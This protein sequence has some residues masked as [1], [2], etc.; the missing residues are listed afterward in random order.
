MQAWVNGHIVTDPDAPAV[1]VT[2]RGFT[3]GAGVFETLKVLDG[4]PFALT[5]HL[6]RLNHGAAVLGIDSPDDALVRRGVA[7]VLAAEAHPLQRLR[8]TW[9]GTTLAITSTAFASYSPTTA[10]V[11]S[12]WPRNE[13]SPLVG[14]KSTAFAENILSTAHAAKHD[15]GEAIL[16]NLNGDLC[17][18]AG[19]N[20]FYVLDGELRTPT[21]E[22]GCLPG[23]TRDLVLEWFGAREVDAPLG[24]L[25][26][27]D[28]VFL[29]SS[30]R[31]VQ[32]VHAID[33]RALGAPGPVTTEVA[34]VWAER[35]AQSLDP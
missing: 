23:V 2:D 12:P 17:E 35:E 16:A 28:E 13:R 31:N 11:T 32:G 8:I 18:G 27:A 9:T 25:L 1:A 6:A 7:E 4:T 22:S 15:A 5:R 19:S 21:L 26:E 14:I 3:V 30:T 10:I 24:V 20:I 34:R 33:G 29:A